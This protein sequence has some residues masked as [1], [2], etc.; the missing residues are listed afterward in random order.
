MNKEAQAR[1]NY[2]VRLT[3][4][5]KKML[6]KIQKDQKISVLNDV[7]ALSIKKVAEQNIALK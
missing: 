2:T 6:I 4:D 3:E 5:V 1:Y 7:F